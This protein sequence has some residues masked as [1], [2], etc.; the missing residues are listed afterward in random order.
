MFKIEHGYLESENDTQQGKEMKWGTLRKKE[1]SQEQSFSNMNPG[2]R[3][4]LLSVAL[5]VNASWIFR[6]G[7]NSSVFKGSQN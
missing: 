1:N 5:I 7:V 2:A 4:M 6:L 3:F